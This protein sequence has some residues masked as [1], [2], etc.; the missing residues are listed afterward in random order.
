ML[1]EAIGILHNSCAGRNVYDR[2][3]V[4]ICIGV[5]DIVGVIC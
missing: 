1:F 5:Q 3:S 2:S 4:Q